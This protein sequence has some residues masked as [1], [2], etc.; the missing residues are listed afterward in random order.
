MSAERQ[1]TPGEVSRLLDVPP[2]T[3]RR[4]VALL[5]EYLSPEARRQ[6]ARLFTMADVEILARVR[7]LTDQGMHLEDIGPIIA[8]TI[9]QAGEGVEYPAGAP[10]AEDTT[11]QTAL[12]VVARISEKLDRVNRSLADQAGDLQALRLQLD[13]QAR[14]LAELEAWRALPWWQRFGKKPPDA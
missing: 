3:L 4:H 13:Q 7:Q 14:R 1:F 11:E 5:G 8:A 2:S 10:E 9:E 12:M 6:R